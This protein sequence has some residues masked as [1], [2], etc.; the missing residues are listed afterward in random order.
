[1]RRAAAGKAT[2]GGSRHWPPDVLCP[3]VSPLDARRRSRLNGRPTWQPPEVHAALAGGICP[4]RRPW[5]SAGDAPAGAPTGRPPE[6]APAGGPRP[7]GVKTIAAFLA[8]T[9]KHRGSPEGLQVPSSRTVGHLASTVQAPPPL[10]SPRSPAHLALP[11]LAPVTPGLV[12]R[13]PAVAE[14]TLPS[15]PLPYPHLPSAP[16]CPCARDAAGR[17]FHTPAASGSQS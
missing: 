4:L 2:A 13:R 6:L 3:P 1:M 15:R 10:L 8:G 11:P 12:L 7:G 16:A 14:H 9:R 17:P 5:A